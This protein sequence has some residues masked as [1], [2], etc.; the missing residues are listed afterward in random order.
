M[1]ELASGP[2]NLEA[3]YRYSEAVLRLEQRFVVDRETVRLRASGPSWKL[4]TF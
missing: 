3:I 1:L 2:D 4:H